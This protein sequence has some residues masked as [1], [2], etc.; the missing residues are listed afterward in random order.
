MNSRKNTK[1]LRTAALIFGDFGIVFIV[2]GLAAWSTFD[3]LFS[4]THAWVFYYGLIWAFATVAVNAAFGIYRMETDN[5]GLFESLRVMLVTMILNI[6]LYVMMYLLHNLSPY[7]TYI[8]WKAF[9]LET[10]AELFFLVVFRFVRRV[11]MAVRA[12]HRK[13][14]NPIRT[15]V[16]GAGGAA[17]IVID[18][19]RSNP[20]SSISVV[21]LVDD[22]PNKIGNTLS[23]IRILGPISSIAQFVHMY[24]AEEV[25]IAV[26][27]LSEPRLHQILEYLRSCNVRIRRL[28]LLSEME[29]LHEMKVIDVDYEE[30]LGRGGVQVDESA[31]TEMLK[32]Q[33]ILVTGA[34]GSIGSGIAVDIAARSPK[35]IILFDFYE[36]GLYDTQQQIRSLLAK[37]GN[38]PV[39][40]IPVVGSTFHEETVTRLFSDYHPDFV[41]HAASYKQVPLMEDNPNEAIRANAIG[42]YLIA[43]AASEAGTKKFVILSSNKAVNPMNVMAATKRFGEMCCEHFAKVS[44]TSFACVRFGNVLATSGSVVPLFASQIKAGGPVTVT[45]A[46]MS[47]YFMSLDEAV[48]LILQSSVYSSDGQVFDIDMGQPVKILYVAEQMIRQAGYLPYKDIDIKITGLRRGEIENELPDFDK[49]RRKETPNERIFIDPDSRDY[50]IAEMYEKLLAFLKEDPKEQAVAKNVIDLVLE[51]DSGGIKK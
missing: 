16:I 31:I 34:G 15:I 44:K 4:A 28:P 12:K 43:K 38:S 5:F 47:R 20:E 23:G 48:K 17:K 49:R 41:Y 46:N 30:L 22:D 7:F 51:Y 37:T 1:I 19:S 29:N 24:K 27:A 25:I 40:I 42:T 45:S 32:G 6:V 3:N 26:A 14:E 2:Y 50:P 36:A 11:F 18:D 33:T 10:V 13:R 9:A 39:Q 21:R 35:A 8:N